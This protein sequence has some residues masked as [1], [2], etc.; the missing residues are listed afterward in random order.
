MH[1]IADGTR[2]LE[3]QLDLEQLRFVAENFRAKPQQPRVRRERSENGRYIEHRVD[4]VMPLRASADR[5]AQGIAAEAIDGGHP[6]G[7]NA[8]GIGL[9]RQ[10]KSRAVSRNPAGCSGPER[11]RSFGDARPWSDPHTTWHWPGN[12]AEIV[13]GKS[14]Q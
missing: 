9:L 13:K 14:Q 4:A 10:K 2:R 8:K 11:S 12:V 5:S 6:I 1:A 7:L 3:D